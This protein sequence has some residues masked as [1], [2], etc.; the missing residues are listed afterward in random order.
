MPKEA[1][2]RGAYWQSHGTD[3]ED[4][5]GAETDTSLDSGH[6]EIDTSGLNGFNQSEASA[7]AYWKYRFSQTQVAK[8][9][10]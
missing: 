4:D 8:A 2:G 9:L 7:H 10:K 3:M 1:T 5:S 6:E